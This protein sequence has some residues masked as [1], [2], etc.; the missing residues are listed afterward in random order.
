MQRAMTIKGFIVIMALILAVFLCLHLIMKGDLSRKA[1]QEAAL[2]EALA[3]LQEEQ[4]D[5]RNQ[6]EVVGTEDFILSSAKENYSFVNRD[7]I[8]FEFTNPEALYAYTEEEL[9]ILVDEVAD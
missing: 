8:R 2:Q 6:L 1:E 7:D 4:K 3:A 5:L 9:R